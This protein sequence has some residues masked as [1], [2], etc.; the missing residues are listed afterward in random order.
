MQKIPVPALERKT[1][2]NEVFV[3]SQYVHVLEPLG[4]GR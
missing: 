4:Q 3:V 1:A 2:L